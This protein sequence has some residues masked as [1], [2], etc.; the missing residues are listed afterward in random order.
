VR[1]LEGLNAG[2]GLRAGTRWSGGRGSDGVEGARDGV[3][4]V[5]GAGQDQVVVA[6]ELLQTGA[7]S[8]VVD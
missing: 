1:G 5:E 6:V 7:E 3:D 2:R 8:A 4:A